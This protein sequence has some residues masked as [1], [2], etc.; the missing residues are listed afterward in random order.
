MD[1]DGE[2]SETFCVFVVFSHSH[3]L[4]HARWHLDLTLT[5]KLDV[6]NLSLDKGEEV[7][8]KYLKTRGRVEKLETFDNSS[9]INRISNPFKENKTRT[10]PDKNW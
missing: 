2:K 9:I 1:A 3:N 10:T 4:L 6:L 7:V 5:R 8:I